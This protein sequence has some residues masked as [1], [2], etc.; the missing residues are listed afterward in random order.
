MQYILFCCLT[1]SVGQSSVEY[2]GPAYAN[3][4]TKSRPMIE[5]VMGALMTSCV[6]AGMG[7]YTLDYLFGRPDL[8]EQTNKGPEEWSYLKF[9]VKVFYPV[10]A[11][12]KV[13]MN[14]ERLDGM[15]GP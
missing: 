2:T 9:G 3:R 13:A 8:I 5:D 14:G 12:K 4:D 10:K 6:R 1:V 15:I 11:F 7:P